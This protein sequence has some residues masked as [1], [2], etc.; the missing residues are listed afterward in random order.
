M[1]SNSGWMLRLTADRAGIFR[2]LKKH[3]GKGDPG[4]EKEGRPQGR[5]YS[6]WLDSTPQDHDDQDS[7]FHGDLALENIGELIEALALFMPE[8][9]PADGAYI[10]EIAV[11]SSAEENGCEAWAELD[12]RRGMANARIGYSQD[13]RTAILEA[14]QQAHYALGKAL[15]KGERP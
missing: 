6:E 14:A 15:E 7:P 4:S 10:E 13:K 11:V 5:W 3:G 1:K 9:K 8:G 2:I 12:M